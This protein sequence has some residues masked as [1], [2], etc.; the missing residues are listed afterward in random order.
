MNTQD[1]KVEFAEFIHKLRAIEHLSLRQISEIVN[2]YENQ[3][4]GK[5]LCSNA[6][7]LLF[8]KYGKWLWD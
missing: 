7:K 5:E 6:E 1:F 2:G 4:D 3:I 8:D